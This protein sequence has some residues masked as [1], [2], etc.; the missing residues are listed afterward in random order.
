MRLHPDLYTAVCAYIELRYSHWEKPQ[1][2][3]R[4]K[5]VC[6]QLKRENEEKR[7]EYLDKVNNCLKIN[8]V[9]HA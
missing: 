4:R 9:S 1:R 5:A 8:N 6:A 7:Q 3:A 2:V